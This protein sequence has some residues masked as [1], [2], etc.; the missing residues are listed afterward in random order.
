VESSIISLHLF[1]LDHSV[2]TV[3][4]AF[5]L[6]LIFCGLLP[7]NIS[8]I[9]DPGYAKNTTTHTDIAKGAL[10]SGERLD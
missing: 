4:S 6:Y 9:S 1:V 2:A 5:I 3:R 8:L 7:S 10:S